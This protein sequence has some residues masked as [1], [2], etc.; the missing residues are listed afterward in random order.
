M[1][2]FR[3]LGMILTLGVLLMPVAEV[4]AIT[5]PSTQI[6]DV[7][8]SDRVV[9]VCEHG[10]AKSLIAAAYFNKLAAERGLRSRAIFRGITPHQVL[11]VQA[12]DG[13]R[14]DDVPIPDVRPTQ[15]GLDELAWAKDVI[16]VGC[17]LPSTLALSLKVID[18]NDVPDEAG[19]WAMRDAIVSHVRALL[20]EIQRRQR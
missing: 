10:A 18:W 8:E 13:L 9:F 5:G 14:S 19:Y 15:V 17:A 6:S 3:T 4:V 7:R 1:Q 12:V 2:A 16:A 20:D 11:S